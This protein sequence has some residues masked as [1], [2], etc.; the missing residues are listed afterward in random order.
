M[1][2]CVCVLW[3]E[4]LWHQKLC[5]LLLLLALS[6]SYPIFAYPLH[7]SENAC[8]Q[9]WWWWAISFHCCSN[10]H[11]HT[12]THADK[13]LGFGL[14]RAVKFLSLLLQC[15]AN[16]NRILLLLHLLLRTASS[17]V[18]ARAKSNKRQLHRNPEGKHV[19]CVLCGGFCALWCV[20]YCL[21]SFLL[22]LSPAREYTHTPT[23]PPT[24]YTHQ[25]P[26][27]MS[28]ERTRRRS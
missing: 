12:Q 22:V 7:Y 3:V 28:T 9:W 20:L 26:G 27:L 5:L 21:C 17:C 2:V 14:V 11:T 15:P 19:E 23:H 8:K 13:Q 6:F 18:C 24:D 10:K 16:T 4:L 25:Q 1:H